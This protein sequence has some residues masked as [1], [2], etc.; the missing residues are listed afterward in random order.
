MKNL[1]ELADMRNSPC[2]DTPVVAVKDTGRG[3]TA[4]LR[5]WIPGALMVFLAGFMLS[6]LVRCSGHTVRVEDGLLSDLLSRID[7][8]SGY[9]FASSAM[10]LC[11]VFLNNFLHGRHDWLAICEWVLCGSIGVGTVAIAKAATRSAW[12]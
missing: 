8:R 3:P 11:G 2:P 12:S 1:A 9:F 10:T 6:M 4:I 7:N 5:V